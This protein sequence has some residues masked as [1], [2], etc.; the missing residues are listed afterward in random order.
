MPL[1]SVTMASYNHEKFIAEAIESVLGQDFD[2]LE[3]IIVDD[4]STDSSR[5]IIQKYA[6]EDAR[7][8]V[9]LH[10][11]NCG[12]AKTVNDGIEAAKG[13]FIADIASDDVWIKDKLTKQLAVTACDD[14]LVVWS[15]GE[16]IDDKGQALEKTFT[17][18]HRATSRR[19]SGDIFEELLR[20]NYIF[21]T[22]L[23]YKRSNLGTIRYDEGLMFANDHKFVLELARN[24]NFYYI[25]EP[26][27]KY[28]IHGSNTIAGS[29]SDVKERRRAHH[30]EKVSI[31]DEMLRQHNRTISN[32]T[33]ATMYAQMSCAHTLFGESKKALGFYLQAIRYNPYSWS[34]LT[35]GG[36]IVESLLKNLK[37]RES[38][39]SASK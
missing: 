5:P 7:V 26:L 24:Y 37:V 18:M 29:S 12:I 34:I 10:E 25:A 15:E 35:S 21:G 38:D 6:A 31:Y 22:T 32:K 19:K 20:G 39:D 23:L 11:T 27:A 8:R 2:D 14:D 1:V 13:K 3:L 4:A 16:L 28:R 30:M 36:C 9:T 33:K 17:Q